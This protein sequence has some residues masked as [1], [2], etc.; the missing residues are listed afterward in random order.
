LPLHSSPPHDRAALKQPQRKHTLRLDNDQTK[1][2]YARP[3]VPLISKALPLVKEDESFVHSHSATTPPKS[4]GGV[5]IVS[6]SNLAVAEPITADPNE[7]DSRPL[8]GLPPYLYDLQGKITTEQPA[9]GS[10][11]SSTTEIP[12]DE[13]TTLPSLLDFTEPTTKPPAGASLL[14]FLYERDDPEATDTSPV[15]LS[16]LNDLD[17][18][19]PEVEPDY[20]MLNATRIGLT[21]I[22]TT[23]TQLRTFVKI[24]IILKVSLLIM[25]IGM[26][27]Y[28]AFIPLMF[29]GLIASLL[30]LLTGVR[31]RRQKKIAEAE[32]RYKSSL[33]R[34]AG[35][36]GMLIANAR[37]EYS[38]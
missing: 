2:E 5:K 34:L 7:I 1:D 38:H 17:T 3:H 14:G 33:D 27:V 15:I 13:S 23:F 22:I 20:D 8:L 26:G 25:V 36:V 35:H 29:A 10:S 30:I 31:V 19:A 24:I 28:K 9:T 12:K 11:N 37:Q 21:Q 6:S 18:K 4:N 16:I 32:P